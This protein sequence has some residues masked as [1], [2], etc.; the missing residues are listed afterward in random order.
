MKKEIQKL[1]NK[2]DPETKEKLKK[3]K[4]E[5][6][7]RLYRVVRDI[8]SHLIYGGIMIGVLSYVFMIYLVIHGFN[9]ENYTSSMKY[10]DFSHTD[11]FFHYMEQ[12]NEPLPLMLQVEHDMITP[13][14]FFQNYLRRSL[15][16]HI[17]NGCKHWGA[18]EKWSMSYLT[19]QIGNTLMAFNRIAR[20]LDHNTKELVPHNFTEG[21]IPYELSQLDGTH[22][23]FTFK[24][25]AKMEEQMH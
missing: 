15:P 24:E 23:I 25:F 1:A 19:S 17:V 20:E 8:P 21:V 16:V 11:P 3:K 7:S 22:Y 18:Y 4:K 2:I 14:S 10:L 13:K 6:V 9:V 5:V 12:K